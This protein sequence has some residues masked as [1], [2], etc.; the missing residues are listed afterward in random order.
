MVADTRINPTGELPAPL[1]VPAAGAA[2]NALDGYQQHADRS[3]G[4]R[5]TFT[6]MKGQFLIDRDGIV[7]W[8]NIE[9]AKEGLAG[10]GK[11]P[12]HDELMSAVSLVMG[13][14]T[15]VGT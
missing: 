7:R 6:Q 15:G 10:L 13:D 11:S 8:A 5:A 1:P 4:R 14:G 2:L 9:C 3:A 12:S